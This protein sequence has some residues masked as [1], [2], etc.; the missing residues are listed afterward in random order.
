MERAATV[1]TVGHSNHEFDH[2]VGLLTGEQIKFVVDVRSSPYSRF[3]PQFNRDA[4]KEQ[5]PRLEVDYLYL[6][7]ELGGRPSRDDHYDADGHALYEPM[8]LELAFRTGV[9]RVKKGVANHHRIAL[10]CSE[11]DPTDCHRRLLVGRV[12]TREGLRIHHILPDG[13]IHE[14]DEVNLGA[15]GDQA[16]LFEE[17]V[18]WRSTQS[19]SP[20]QRPNTSSVV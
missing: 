8:S 17:G 14:E 1:W 9:E 19:V 5:L 2:F 18:P 16:P 4:L 6:G 10:M 13:S 12:L 3:A 20:R 15:V 11:S 7:D